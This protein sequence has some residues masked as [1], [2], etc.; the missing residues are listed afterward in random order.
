MLEIACFN[1]SS[2]IAAAEAGAD[3]IELCA[4]YA[5]GG[6]TPTI[7]WLR[8][9]RKVTSTP[10]YVM[11]RPRGGDF[12]YTVDEFEQMKHDITQFK[13][14]ASGFVFG[15]LDSAVRVDEERNGD[16]V[17]LAHPLPC[18]F[19]RAIDETEDMDQAV[20][21]VIRCAFKNILTSGGERNAAMGTERVAKLQKDFGE[22]ITFILG[23]GVR[24]TNLEELKR[25]TSVG[26]FHSA[27]ITRSG[28]EVDS[29]EVTNMQK[30]FVNSKIETK[31]S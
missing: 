10:V 23:G 30:I 15:I 29:Q 14:A 11:I 1:T 9:I 16:L 31:G 19:H 8:N 26:W 17:R 4:D 6:T 24:S 22:H 12:N 5:A 28:E 18:T 25:R 2:A 13:P 3:R 7:D 20:E 21:Q 27:A